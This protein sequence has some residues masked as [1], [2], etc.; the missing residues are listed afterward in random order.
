[1]GGFKVTRSTG[2]A[3]PAFLALAC[4]GFVASAPAHAANGPDDDK[5]AATA[6]DG[7]DKDQITVNGQVY[8]PKQESPKNTRPLRDTP[9][10][11]TVITAEVMAQQNILSLRDAL[12]TV[13]GITFGAGEGG[14]GYGD[15][16][17]LRGFSANN[18]IT[19]DNV[20]DS[21]QYTRSDNFNIEQ[22]EVTNGP[23][24]AYSGS[25]S[26]GGNI[27]LVSKRPTGTNRSV[28]QAGVGTDDYYRATVD[29]DRKLSDSVGVRL[30]AMYHHN[31]I[32]GREV[33]YNKR[34]GVM[35]SIT[36]GL[37]GPTKFSLIYLHQ[38]DNN[39]PQFG[40]P[41][42]TSAS[43]GFTGQVPG[44]SRSAYYGFR[45]L[46]KQ[47][48]N[49]DQG[50][51]IFEQEVS[52]TVS[53][54]NLTRYQDVQQYSIADGP[55]GTF[56]LPTGFT[57]AGVA[58]TTPGLFTPSGGS[59]GNTRDTR[60]QI[61]YNQTDLKGTVD[62]F[63]IEHSFDLGFSLSREFYDVRSGNSQRNANG[64][65]VTIPAY[66]YNDP[67][68]NDRNVYTGP[69][70]FIVSAKSHSEVANQAV[71]LFDTMKL[72]NHFELNGGV[73]LERNIG[74]FTAYTISTAAATLGQIT[75]VTRSGNRNT[76]FSYRVGA[77]FKP[78]E[79]IS[80]YVAYGNSRT[81]S[82]STVNGSCSATTCNVKPESAK[83]YEIGG[84]AELFNKGLLLTAALFRTDRDSYKVA[85]VDPTV[86]DQQLDGH[87]RV[88]GVA[89]GATGHITS[90]WQIT[91]NYTYLDSELIR[92]VAKGAALDPSAGAQLQ[93]TPKHSGSLYTA[94]TLPFGL[95]VG[96][97]ATYQGKFAINLPTRT[98][99]GGA[100]S[101]VL[102]SKDYLV[103]NLTVAYDVT[104]ALALQLNV[105]NIGDKLYYTRIRANNG[106]ATPGDARSAILT[107]TYKF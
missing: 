86:P 31:D 15:S 37:G 19:I 83:N 90:A 7:Q 24:S 14:S 107:A 35:P 61:I 78:I 36:F 93:Q 6:D 12:A 76:L 27:N 38:E 33:E 88:D 25:G 69:V 13:P 71:Y 10:T 56:C 64:T 45:N 21:A 3:A 29:I 23:N 63:G 17:N 92:S 49:V 80:L 30:N 79:P 97:G 73:R 68:L 34:W 32:P 40:V 1:M 94:Y 82:Q 8:Q 42:V 59:R 60:N 99:V 95:T 26:V 75:A 84:K 62:T 105:K 89:L 67:N 41:Y 87:S 100:L 66:A 96:Y 57:A 44:T 77:V 91:A 52:S 58:C 9:Q 16:I 102:Y 51:A 85:S 50:T 39:I 18:D 55:E 53:L 81:P 46:D 65:T 70:N 98:V 74:E 5:K 48:S 11:V 20:R 4:V 101:Q 54:R 47:D 2:A 72:S 106:W 43:N 103:H 104:R 22:I 28:V